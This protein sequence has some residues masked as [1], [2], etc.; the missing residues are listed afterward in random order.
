LW[1]GWPRRIG[2]SALGLAALVS[3]LFVPAISSRLSK[4]FAGKKDWGRLAIW[5]AA[6]DLAAERPL[7]GIGYGNFQRDAVP[8]VER[9]ANEMGAKRFMG[10]YAWAHSNPLTF[11]AETG[12][13][14]LLAFCWIFVAYYLAARRTL[15]RVRDDPLLRGFL[16]GSMAAVAGFLLVGLFHDTFFDGEVIFSLWFTLGASLAVGRLVPD[17]ARAGEGAP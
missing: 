6:L 15:L 17:G 3:V 1:A 2:L 7:T 5:H 13:L 11:L 4:S 9:R 16:R 14:G 10:V 12:G 8:H